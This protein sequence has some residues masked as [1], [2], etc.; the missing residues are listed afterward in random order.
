MT[1]RVR[2]RVVDTGCG[3][4]VLSE[5]QPYWYWKIEVVSNKNAVQ[6]FTILRLLVSRINKL[7][8]TDCFVLMKIAAIFKKIL[9]YKFFVCFISGPLSWTSFHCDSR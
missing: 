1:E 6:L 3:V 9:R 4:I 7:H 2:G 8:G 5:G